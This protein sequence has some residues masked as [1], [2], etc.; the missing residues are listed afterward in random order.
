MSDRT[1]ALNWWR[2]LKTSDQALA[3]EFWKKQ[4]EKDSRKEWPLSFI[5]LSSS[6]I[7]EIWKKNQKSH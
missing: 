3:V 5:Q 4:P 1:K 2:S 7:E 6:T